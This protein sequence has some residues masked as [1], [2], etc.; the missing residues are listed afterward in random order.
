MSIKKISRRE[1]ISGLVGFLLGG[2]LIYVFDNFLLPERRITEIKTAYETKTKTETIKT[3]KTI[4]ETKTET[5]T[6]T[7][8]APKVEDVRLTKYYSPEKDSVWLYF[9]IKVKGGSNV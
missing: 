5:K 7:F 4:Y 1:Y 6:T 3:T 9:E 2:V 8:Y